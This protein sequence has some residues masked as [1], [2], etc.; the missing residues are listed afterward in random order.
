MADALTGFL[1]WY[2]LTWLELAVAALVSVI[3][4]F[5]NGALWTLMTAVPLWAVSI[6]VAGVRKAFE[7]LGR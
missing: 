1:A 3:S 6:V 2:L 5:I 4:A 7:V